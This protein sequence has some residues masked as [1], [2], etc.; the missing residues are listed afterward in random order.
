MNHGTGTTQLA[1]FAGEAPLPTLS[2][3]PLAGEAAEQVAEDAEAEH[4][5][6]KENDAAIDRAHPSTLPAYYD[7]PDRKLIG[8]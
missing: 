4:N 2:L 8:F 1:N 7:R 5:P 3:G 6:G